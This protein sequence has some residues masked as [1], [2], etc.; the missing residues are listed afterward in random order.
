[1]IAEKRDVWGAY[2]YEEGLVDLGVEDV[3]GKWNI[4][5]DVYLKWVSWEPRGRRNGRKGDSQGWRGEKEI[6]YDFSV[7]ILFRCFILSRGL[8]EVMNQIA[9]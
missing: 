4:R 2:M 7:K 9:S 8:V 5:F 6:N 3:C 1:M